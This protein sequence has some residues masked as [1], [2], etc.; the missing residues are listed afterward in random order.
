VLPAINHV[1][2]KPTDWEMGPAQQNK[3]QPCHGE[4]QSED[5]QHLSD[6]GHK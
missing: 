5:D 1:T 4:Q 6:F 3:N 2:G